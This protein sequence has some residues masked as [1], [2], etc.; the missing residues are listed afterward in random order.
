MCIL[1]FKNLKISEKQMNIPWFGCFP[2]FSC[3]S[4]SQLWCVVVVVW[5]DFSSQ[6]AAEVKWVDGGKPLFKVNLQLNSTIY[7]KDQHLHMFFF[8]CQKMMSAP[9]PGHDSLNKL[10]VCT[11]QIIL[12]LSVVVCVIYKHIWCMCFEVNVFLVLCFFKHREI[13]FSFL[14]CKWNFSYV[15]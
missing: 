7:T 11:S 4:V 2:V 9:S 3:F 12:S 13:M 5:V 1:D 10:K 15:Y 14:C 8:H 6:S